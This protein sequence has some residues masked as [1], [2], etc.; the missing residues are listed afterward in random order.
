[1]E[2]SLSRRELINS[3]CF[4]ENLAFATRLFITTVVII[5]SIVNLSLNT[6]D[7]VL[8]VSLLSSCIGLAYPGLNSEIDFRKLSERADKIDR[9]SVKRRSAVTNE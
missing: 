2:R 6:P 8:W 9:V 1:M 4:R 5:T 3:T 7:K